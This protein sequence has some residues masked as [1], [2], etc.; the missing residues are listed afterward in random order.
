[1]SSKFRSDNRDQLFLL[2]PSIQEWLPENHLARFVVDVVEQLDLTDISEKYTGNGIPAY[3]PDLMISLLF[4]AYASGVFSSRAIERSTYDSISFRYI[5]A[6]AHPDHATI[7]AFRKRFLDELKPLFVQI[8]VIA[9]E[10]GFLKLGRV[11]LDGT[12]IKANASKHRALSW[13]HANKLEKQFKQ[14]I[15]ELLLLAEIAD[16]KDLPD[17]LSIPDELAIR[18]KRLKVI[19]QAK[20]KIEERAKTKYEEELRDFKEKEE[21]RK[22]KETETGKKIGGKKPQEPELGPKKKDQ[23]SL[24]DDESRIMRTNQGFDQCYNSQAV[25]EI[26]SYIVIENHVSQSSNDKKEIEPT[27]KN[28]DTLPEELGKIEILLADNGYFSQNNVDLCEIDNII[29]YISAGRQKHNESLIERF[30]SSGELPTTANAV[31]KMK[32][33]LKTVEGKKI[34]SK[35]KST[36]ETVFGM[37][38]GA[39]GFRQFLLRGHEAVSG[40][41]NLVCIGHNLKRLHS[42][43]IM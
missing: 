27:L 12:K 7:S 38:K 3:H 10:M 2:P 34:Y 28:L 18:E 39:L 35:R 4:Y 19:T 43:A 29:P 17:E 24:T 15:K 11:S 21:N 32:H 1:M 31:D 14:E 23:I 33:R 40:E 42:M 13:G 25:V 36:I 16:K 5:T 30:T 8:L 20:L 26:D 22:K 9:H 6:N 41:W 37:I